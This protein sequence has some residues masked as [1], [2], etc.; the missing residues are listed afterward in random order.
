MTDLT[1]KVCERLSPQQVPQAL[2]HA[3]FTPFL[4]HCSCRLKDT[5][6]AE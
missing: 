5:S 2:I 1:L 3:C 4:K 6:P